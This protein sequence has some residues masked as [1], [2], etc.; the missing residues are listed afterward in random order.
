MLRGT[1]HR[2]KL[3]LVEDDFDLSAALG[4]TLLQRGYDVM[5]CADG[6]EAL[7]LLRKRPYD[8]V[9]LD[10]SLPGLDG[11]DVLQRLRDDGNR[12]PVLV[13]TARG[14]VG[15][16]IQGLNAGADDYLAKPF[17]LD[18]LIARLQALTRRLGRD[19]DLRCGLVRHEALSGAFY[20]QAIPLE[21]SPREGDLLKALMSAVDRVVPKEALT[22]AVFA[23]S[24]AVQADAIEVLVHRL[25]RKL[26]GTKAEIMTLRGVGYLLRDDAVGPAAH[27]ASR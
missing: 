10:L 27:R 24:E 7:G 20:V 13:L 14:A 23:G 9:V 21:L 16:R 1:M 12:T 19:G 25:R 4:Q 22:S 3:L 26:V 18:E 2:M 6:H 17:D 15:E 11:I 8:L 5:R